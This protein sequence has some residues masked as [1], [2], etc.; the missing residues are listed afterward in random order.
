MK[1]ILERLLF[2]A[3]V[4]AVAY[5]L[6]SRQQ[7][8]VQLK[9]KLQEAK[10]EQGILKADLKSAQKRAEARE[11]EEA[12]KMYSMD[13][14]MDDLEEHGFTL[15]IVTVEAKKKMKEDGYVC[16]KYDETGLHAN[17]Q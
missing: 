7:E 6:T 9:T 14:L 5:T 13:L 16:I 1:K 12:E 4:T 2:L 15:L 3:F 8:A 10:H 17:S 11:I